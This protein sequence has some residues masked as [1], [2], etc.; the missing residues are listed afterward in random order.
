MDGLLH[1]YSFTHTKYA[2]FVFPL[3]NY[4]TVIECKKGQV[5]K[6]CKNAQRKIDILKNRQTQARAAHI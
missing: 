6:R 2:L 3:S 1:A 5:V 4:K